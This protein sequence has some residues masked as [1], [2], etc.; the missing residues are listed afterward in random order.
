MADESEW[1]Y[2]VDEIDDVHQSESS[3]VATIIGFIGV[4]GLLLFI[5]YGVT[6]QPGA[7]TPDVTVIDTETG[8]D[9]V[10]ETIPYQYATLTI[11]TSSTN[12]TVT[13]PQTITLRGVEANNITITGYKSVYRGMYVTSIESHRISAPQ[14]NRS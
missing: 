14:V 10:I 9:V 13:E 1:R 7:A 12:K 11:N 8:S 4:V 2:S 6:A 5:L 3:R